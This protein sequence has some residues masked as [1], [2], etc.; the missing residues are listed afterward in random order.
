MLAQ[1]SAEEWPGRERQS[2]DGT[3]D[4]DRHVAG[5]GVGEG[6]GDDGERR[7]RE[8]GS[9]DA[10]ER[11]ARD[12]RR[13]VSGETREERCHREDAK[14]DQ[15]EAAAAEEVGE[16]SADQHEPRE[17]EDVGADDPLDARGRQV[18]VFLDHRDGDVDDVVVEVGH[19]RREGDGHESPDV[20]AI[21]HESVPRK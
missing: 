16:P 10:L 18:K 7:R 4:A 1:D 3:P 19:E 13:H 9:A 17:R 5:A 11:A 12:E 21:V 20:A 14:A 2:A 15:E 6:R 8:E